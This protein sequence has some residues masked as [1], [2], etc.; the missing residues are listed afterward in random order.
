MTLAKTIDGCTILSNQGLSIFAD[1]NQFIRRH[2]EKFK[3]VIVYSFFSLHN[4]E[5]DCCTVDSGSWAR[6]L[7]TLRKKLLVG[8]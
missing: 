7:F 6:L 3:L 5:L 1:Y 8:N 2:S 4:L